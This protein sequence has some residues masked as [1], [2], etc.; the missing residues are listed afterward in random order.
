MKSSWN[1]INHSKCVIRYFFF[2]FYL[3]FTKRKSYSKRLK[4]YFLHKKEET[5]KPKL[6][7]TFW[8]TNIFGISKKLKNEKFKNK[9]KKQKISLAKLI[10]TEIES[11]LNKNS[12]LSLEILIYICVCICNCICMCMCKLVFLQKLW[13]STQMH[14]SQKKKTTKKKHENKNKIWARRYSLKK[15]KY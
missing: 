14:F 2:I 13:E 4:F 12:K 9:K 15:K 6:N 1:K 10:E 8:N 7:K 5:N 11:K 3:M